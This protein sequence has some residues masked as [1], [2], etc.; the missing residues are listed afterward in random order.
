[1]KPFN[2]LLLLFLTGTVLLA[3]SCKKDDKKN[4]VPDDQDPK[5]SI[6]TYYGT[7]TTLS[8]GNARTFVTIQDGYPTTI[9]IRISESALSGLPADSTKEW[10]YKLPMPT[11]PVSKLVG[12]DHIA[13]DWNPV[14]HDPKPIY[15]LPHFDF[16][17]YRITEY[18]QEQVVGG[19]DKVAV[20]PVFIPRDYSPGPVAIA[21]PMMGVHWSD[22]KAPEFNGQK[23]TDTFIY[24][25]YQGKLT[26]MEPMATLAYIQSKPDFKINIK[27]PEIYPKDGYYPMVSHLYYDAG[28]K[29]YVMALEKLTYKVFLN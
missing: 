27:Q 17:F 3:T 2:K 16:H 19:P 23:F 18:E 6:Q 7:S 22:V 9:G 24:G 15:G 28:S 29:E 21:V 14:G 11:A 10:E 12:F 25:F 20:N 8:K 1:M 5:P 26:F 4:V 13:V